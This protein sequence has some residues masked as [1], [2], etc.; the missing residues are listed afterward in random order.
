VITKSFHG[1]DSNN[2]ENFNGMVCEVC[3]KATFGGR[4]GKCS[5]AVGFAAA[6]KNI[7]RGA[8]SRQVLA[9]LSNIPPS[10]AAKQ[11][12]EKQSHKRAYGK[13]YQAKPKAKIRRLELKQ[14][15]K[16]TGNAG[17]DEYSTG[18]ALHE[19]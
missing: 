4:R 17:N 9:E 13:D 18:R 12:G 5:G 19:M 14:L 7:G 15:K 2:N 3:P 8:A 16:V 10:K 6:S 1:D 11:W